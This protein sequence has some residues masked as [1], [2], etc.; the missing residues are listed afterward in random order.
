MR[1]MLLFTLV[2]LNASLATNVPVSATLTRAVERLQLGH[3]ES[4]LHALHRQRVAQLEAEVALVAD[5]DEPGHLPAEVVH[6]NI[7]ITAIYMPLVRT[8]MIAPTKMYENVPTLS[9]EQAADLVVEAIVYKPVRIAT[10]RV[11]GVGESFNARSHE[12]ATS[13]LK[14]QVEGASGSPP[15]PSTGDAGAWLKAMLLL[16]FAYGGFETA[17]TPLSEARKRAM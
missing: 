16:V 15:L 11:L 13:M 9:P 2:I 6:K 17:L 14:R 8:P 3:V 1:V 5:F 10:R 7:N 12:V 4:D